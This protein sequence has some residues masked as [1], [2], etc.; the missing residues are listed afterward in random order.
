[1]AKG[2]VIL[3]CLLCIPGAPLGFSMRW[4]SLLLSSHKHALQQSGAGTKDLCQ[5]GGRGEVRIALLIFDLFWHGIIFL[6][7]SDGVISVIFVCCCF[8]RETN[9]VHLLNALLL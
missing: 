9:V 4:P 8:L 1:M 7:Y 3:Q 2:E 5:F 6:Y